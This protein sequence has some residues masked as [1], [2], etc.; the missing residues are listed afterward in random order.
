MTEQSVHSLE[1][2]S[3]G[4]PGSTR[5][6]T[7]LGSTVELTLENSLRLGLGRSIRIESKD[8]VSLTLYSETQNSTIYQQSLTDVW[9][10]IGYVCRLEGIRV[11]I[12]FVPLLRKERFYV[13][14]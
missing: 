14:H 6:S 8:R 3:P 4:R 11:S 9:S 13:D 1:E 2:P 10:Y 12:P 7:T 5:K